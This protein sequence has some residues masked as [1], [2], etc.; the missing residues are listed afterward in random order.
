[1]DSPSCIDLLA[2][3][4]KSSTPNPKKNPTF[5]QTLERENLARERDAWLVNAT[6]DT[7]QV[8]LD[9]IGAKD[10]DQIHWVDSFQPYYL[11]KQENEGEPIKKVN[12]FT[13][14]EWRWISWALTG[15]GCNCSGWSRGCACIHNA[16]FSSK[17][18]ITSGSNGSSGGL[19]TGTIKA[20]KVRRPSGQSFSNLIYHPSVGQ[21]SKLPWCAK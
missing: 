10:L 6:Y 2:L 20:D 7:G 18:N 12:L 15:F 19:P 21:G 4:V 11:T 17:K 1:M 14:D 3:I 16:A 9:L 8:H 5:N 13:Q